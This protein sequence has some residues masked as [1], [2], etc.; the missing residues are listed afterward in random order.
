M[1]CCSLKSRRANVSLWSVMLVCAPLQIA[2]GLS[3]AALWLP[4]RLLPAAASTRDSLDCLL[5]RNREVVNRRLRPTGFRCRVAGLLL[6]YW[7]RL[8][9][10]VFRNAYPAIVTSPWIV[11]T[12]TLCV[13]IVWVV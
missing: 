13:A 7:P 4:S 9:G 11:A 3:S 12:V 1:G 2:G 5:N 10:L 6:R 8:S